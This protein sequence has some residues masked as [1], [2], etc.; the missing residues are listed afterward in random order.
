[1]KYANPILIVC[2]AALSCP[3]PAQEALEANPGAAG[4]QHGKFVSVDLQRQ[5]NHKLKD[6]LNTEGKD[7]SLRNLSQGLQDFCDIRFQVG[8]GFIRLGGK[9]H[10]ALPA[11]A[12]GIPANGSD[13]RL[14][15]PDL[16]PRR[17]NPTL[18]L[19]LTRLRFG[20]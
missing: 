6:S 8:P 10:T 9:L 12:D 13:R 18:H 16:R 4:K 20:W 7:N 5:A 17:Y 2:L 14:V 11:R 3:L 19:D 15:L 1:M